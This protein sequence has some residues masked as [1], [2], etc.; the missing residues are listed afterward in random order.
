M[1]SRVARLALALVL[2][3][4]PARAQDPDALLREGVAMRHR[5]D[6]QGAQRAFAAAYALRPEPRTAAQLGTTHQAL[7]Q[8]LEAER[9]LRVALRADDPWIAR[10]R[11][12]LEAA[13]AV[14]AR[15]LATLELLGPAGAEVRVDGRELGRLPLAEPL[16]VVAGVMTV[17]VRAEGMETAVRRVVVEPGTFARELFEPRPAP[18]IAP[19]VPPPGPARAID[20]APTIAPA[21]VVFRTVRRVDPAPI[22]LFGLGGAALAVGVTA[23]FAR[24]S[25]AGTYNAGC[26]SAGA[27]ACADLSAQA[28]GWTAAAAVALPLAAIATALGVWRALAR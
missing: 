17:S 24:E 13:A 28:D 16:R 27:G 14:V 26:P 25:V 7:G 6:D 8:W 11:V 20:P 10:H 12:T 22:A 3:A 18:T 19:A 21:R 2:L 4:A 23:V 9:M 1:L 5:G 15:H